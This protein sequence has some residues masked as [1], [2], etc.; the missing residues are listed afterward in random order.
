ME[1]APAG[2]GL[3]NVANGRKEGRKEGQS[4]VGK[5]NSAVG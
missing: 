3:F 2:E 4:W 5:A 1:G